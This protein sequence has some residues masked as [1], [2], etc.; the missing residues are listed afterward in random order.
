MQ[1]RS[2]SSSSFLSSSFEGYSKPTTGALGERVNAMRQA[3]QV[4]LSLFLSLVLLFRFYSSGL[5]VVMYYVF[6]CPIQAFI[7]VF[8]IHKNLVLNPF[9]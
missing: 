2:G 5:Y 6:Y 3:F 4:D 8:K 1:E 9:V 7:D